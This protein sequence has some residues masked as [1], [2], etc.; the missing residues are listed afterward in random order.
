MGRPWLAFWM[1]P[2]P[3][4]RGSLWVNYRSPLVWDVF[5]IS[6]YFT[7]SL[8]FWYLGLVPDFATLRDRARGWRQKLY[9]WLSLG[10]D[11]SARTWQRY[12]KACLLLAG[13]ATPLVVSVHTIVSFDF[14]TSVI[15]GWHTTIFPP[16]F[17]AGAVFCGFAMVMTLLLLTRRVLR[18]RALHHAAPPRLHGQGA[19]SPPGCIVGFAYATEI[20]IAWYSG[21][22]YERFTFWNRAFGP[23][24]WAYWLM[25]FCN[26]VVPQIFWFAQGAALGGRCSSWPR[27]SST[28]GCGSS[29]STSS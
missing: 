21:N 29:A 7:V 5:A 23:Y 17:V 2:Y 3:N 4:T 8:L 19:R 27:S 18:P 11:G 16:Y 12:E 28:W 26:V 10:W 9:G 14:A 15:P 24:A 20:F 1:F 6:T 25:V 22:R 13:L